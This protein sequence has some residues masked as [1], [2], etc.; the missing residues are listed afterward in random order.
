MKRTAL[1]SVF[2]KTGVVDFG[3]RLKDLGFDILAS[4]G[5]ARALTGAGIEVTDVATIVGKPILG[6]RVVTLSREI[7]AALL[8]Q[9]NEIDNA[10]LAS[11]GIPRIDLVYVNMYPLKEEVLKEDHTLASVI[12]KTDI[13][14]PTM[15]RSAAKGRRIVMCR[16]DQIPEVLE[17][18]NQSGFMDGK[19]MKTSFLSKLVSEAE[20]AV[21]SYCSVSAVFHA[22]A[23]QSAEFVEE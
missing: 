11:L 18:I 14:G 2:D 4:G 19:K 15:L 5:T 10:E 7:H 1:L 8:A 23:A 20:D 22:K 3:R 13:G 17:V 12:E 21:S 16:P 9:D 6:H